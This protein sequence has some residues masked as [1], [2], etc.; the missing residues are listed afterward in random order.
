MPAG[1]L[2]LGFIFDGREMN[3][4]RKILEIYHSAYLKNWI[5]YDRN[6]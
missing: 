5:I 3:A 1:K 4:T 6:N 2:G